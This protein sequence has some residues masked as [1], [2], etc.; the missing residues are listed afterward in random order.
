MVGDPME[1]DILKVITQYLRVRYSTV[2]GTA[3]ICTVF[4]VLVT[5]SVG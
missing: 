5:F 1:K 2:A 4:E 3:G